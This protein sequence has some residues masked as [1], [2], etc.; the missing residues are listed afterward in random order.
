MAQSPF[1][2]FEPYGPGDK[3]LFFGRDAEIHALYNLLQQTRLVLVYGAS[4]T[5]KT[6]LLQ[7]GLPKVFKLSDWFHVSIRRRDDLN[8]SLRAELARLSEAPVDDLVAGVEAVYD[9]RWVPLY[10]VFD[11]FEELF[12]LG[13]HAERVQFFQDLQTLLDRPLPCKIVLSMREE[14]IGHLYE[15]EPL[16]PALFE[17]RFR[18]E[19]MKDET[20]R[21]VIV[22]TCAAYNVELAEGPVT[23]GQ[24]LDQVK[25]EKKQAAHLPYLQVYLHY[26]YENALETTGK[27]LFAEAGIQAVGRLGN[28]LKRFIETQLDAARR[29]FADRGLPDEFA[30]RLLD[31][32]ATGEGTKQAQRASELAKTLEAD[33]GQ[34][35]EALRYFTEKK[36]LRADENDVERYEP[37]HDVVAKQIHELRSAEDKE[38]K[39]FVRQLQNDYE[40][41]DALA[42]YIT[43]VPVWKNYDPWQAG[44]PSNNRLL[45]EDDLAKV[46]F[47]L[48]RLSRQ[49]EYAAQWQPFIEASQ[50]FVK[51][52]LNRKRR[53]QQLT[54]AAAI[55]G[56][57][58]AAMAG[59][60]Y[61]QS[62]KNRSLVEIEKTQAVQARQAAEDSAG[63]ARQQR[64]VAIAAQQSAQQE[65]ENAVAALEKSRQDQIKKLL[66]DAS[67]FRKDHRFPDALRAYRDASQLSPTPA[68]QAAIRQQHDQ[69]LREQT[70]FDFERNRGI[71]MA[72]KTANDCRGALIYLKKALLAR[73]DDAEVKKA[74]E[75]CETLLK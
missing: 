68:E 7:A 12:T 21:G 23:A 4:G 69:T 10:L 20:V 38:Y 67:A 66:A 8:E 47:Y 71:G 35:A 41:W 75:A 1:K 33:P 34:V 31:E 61:L 72:L 27:P 63:V 37:V 36:L 25:E 59:W 52:Q 58:L 65:K 48:E 30:A 18:V 11:Q 32:F 26:L 49:S 39:A 70:D 28:V 40:R 45:K 3:N 53:W 73:P 6:S 44:R 60:F 46:E 22:R 51:T 17:K 14:Y 55:L 5:G 42:P 56:F 13:H 15:Y 19:P 54:V 29:H 74:L 57:G 64:L 50:T 43:I 2:L 62:E 16:V 24:I 9:T